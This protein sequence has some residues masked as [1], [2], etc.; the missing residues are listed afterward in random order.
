MEYVDGGSLADLVAKNSGGLQISQALKIV[1]EILKAL[2]RFHGLPDA[3][4]HRDIKPSNIL[5]DR[6]RRAFLGDFGLAQLP[7]SRD[8]PPIVKRHPGTPPYMA[9]EQ[10][11][12]LDPLTP[13]ADLYAVGCVLFETLT[14][15]CYGRQPPGTKARRIRQEVPAWLD[16][17]LNKALAREPSDRY[18]S[19][20]GFSIALASATQL[21]TEAKEYCRLGTE[22]LEND[23]S[24]GA[25]QQLKVAARV[26]DELGI[27]YLKRCRIFR[28]I[29]N[30]IESH[31]LLV[32]IRRIEE[33]G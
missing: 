12:G 29:K 28:S 7:G 5:L 13:A 18:R 30:W 4:V 17:V 24:Q 31:R 33:G 2:A 26:Y 9:P 20:E 15:R 22:S 23:D 3:P 32:E 14:G 10:R 21:E 25:I 19:A 27:R 16:R 6:E 8:N 1:R 11:G